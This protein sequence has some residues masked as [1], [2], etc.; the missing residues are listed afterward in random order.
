VA[1]AADEQLAAV[2]AWRHRD[3]GFAVVRA[4]LADTG[5]SAQVGVERRDQ[6]ARTQRDLDQA[7]LR[8]AARATMASNSVL[9][10]RHY[11]E[12]SFS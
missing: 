7:V 8:R 5:V 6:R 2:G 4:V 10:H 9:N 3:D 1:A 12:R 11:I